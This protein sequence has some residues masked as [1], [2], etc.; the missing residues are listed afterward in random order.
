MAWLMT[1]Y[2]DNEGVTRRM[3]VNTD[4]TFCYREEANGMATAVSIVGISAPTSEP[5]QAIIDEIE[6]AELEYQEPQESPR[7]PKRR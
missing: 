6:A 7:A 4:V 2:L 5:F 1:E 3:M